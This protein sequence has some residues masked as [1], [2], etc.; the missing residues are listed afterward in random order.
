[1]NLHIVVELEITES[2]L[3][4]WK[5]QLK[6]VES[7][8]EKTVTNKSGIPSKVFLTES[9]LVDYRNID[10]R[11]ILTGIISVMPAILPCGAGP[12]EWNHIPCFLH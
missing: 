3:M 2:Y 10:C 6:L 7:Y 8:I 5:I 1:M 4:Y 9:K 12:G 11:I